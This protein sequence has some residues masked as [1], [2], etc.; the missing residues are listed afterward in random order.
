MSGCALE[1]RFEED[2]EHGS[3]AG[4]GNCWR[5]Q[6]GYSCES[7]VGCAVSLHELAFCLRDTRFLPLVR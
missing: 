6:A 3:W 1:L 2:V 4:G 5:W 7:Y